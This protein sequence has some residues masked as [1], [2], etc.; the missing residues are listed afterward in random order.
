MERI[1]LPVDHVP[2]E[3]N[4]EVAVKV[5]EWLADNVTPFVTPK[6]YPVD[7]LAYE[8]GYIYLE[9]GGYVIDPY[10]AERQVNV[11]ATFNV[12]TEH[13]DGPYEDPDGTMWYTSTIFAQ[14]NWGSGGGNRSRVAQL[15]SELIG[16]AAMLARRFDADFAGV[17]I[18]SKGPTRAERKESARKLLVAATQCN[19]EEAIR[20]AIHTTCRGMRVGTSRTLTSP[21]KAVHGDYK[22]A[23]ENKEYKVT[24]GVGQ[25][26]TL[27]FFE[28]KK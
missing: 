21:P 2:T 10:N 8:G 18:W 7:L 16:T 28:R 11:E 22:V 23:L 19:V 6:K 1:L 9:L 3:N 27:M 17:K 14:V 20:E 26:G 4:H 5:R 15:R 13:G 12:A 25:L 24:V